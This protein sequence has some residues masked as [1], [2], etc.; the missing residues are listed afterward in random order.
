MFFKS[1]ERPQWLV[2]FLGNPGD[3]YRDTRH[4]VGFRAG[5]LLASELGVS[6]KKMKFSAKTAQCNIA[7][8]KV[9]LMLPQTYMNRSGDAVYM[10]A[11]NFRILPEHILVVTDETNIEPG[12]IRIRRR[13]SAGGHNGLKSIIMRLGSEDF[14]RIKIGV[15]LPPHP[16]YELAD[17][18]LGKPSGKDAKAVQDAIAKTAQ[19]VQVIISDGVD[20]AM[21]QFN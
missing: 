14:P 8:Q 7:G 2:A 12:R 18:V 13:G 20:A 9:F 10:A 4:N 17:W 11:K 15:G 1:K 6:L 3:M 5:E 21:G 16:E 19:A